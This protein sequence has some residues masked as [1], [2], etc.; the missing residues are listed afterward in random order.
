MKTSVIKT[1]GT[2]RH[3]GPVRERR[4]ALWSIAALRS[5]W[6]VFFLKMFVLRGAR[7]TIVQG[8]GINPWNVAHSFLL[9]EG[10]IRDTRLRSN[11]CAGTSQKRR[12]QWTSG[13]PSPWSTQTTFLVRVGWRLPLD[14]PQRSSF[15]FLLVDLLRRF[16]GGGDESG[17]EAWNL[18]WIWERG[19]P[20]SLSIP[21]FWQGM[22]T[23]IRAFVWMRLLH[24][25]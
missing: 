9:R 2:F 22:R 14:D 21:T 23:V 13:W 20:D 17:R 19:H 6:I 4:R 1:R 12:K 10:K 15:L 11:W 18:G 3:R 5:S 24:R 16:R 25:A 7:S 8:E